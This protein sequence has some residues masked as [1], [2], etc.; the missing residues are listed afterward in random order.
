MAEAHV[1]AALKDK[2]AELSGVI[3]DLEKRIGPVLCISRH[4]SR[5]EY[6]VLCPI[7]ADFG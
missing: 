3:A 2:R 4:Q 6:E 1:V 7:V 5:M